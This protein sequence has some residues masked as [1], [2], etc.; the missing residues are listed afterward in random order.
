MEA[1]GEAQLW[2]EAVGATKPQHWRTCR[3]RPKQG[4]QAPTLAEYNA[5]INCQSILPECIAIAHYQS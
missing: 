3:G 5:K 1:G 2:A 4:A